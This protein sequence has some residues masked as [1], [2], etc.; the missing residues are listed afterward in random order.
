MKKYLTYKDEKSDKFWSIE[1]SDNSFTVVYGK[2]GTTGTSQVKTFKNNEKCLKEANK[3]IKEK[4]AKGY[5]EAEIPATIDNVTPAKKK[6]ASD[7]EKI[8]KE[9]DIT[10]PKRLKIFF[11]SG[12]YK[13]YEGMMVCGLP[14]YTADTKYKVKFFTSGMMNELLED[15]E[16]EMPDD[17]GA[18]Y[19]P[20]IE[21]DEESQFLGIDISKGD[22]CPVAMWEHE[23]GM[24]HLHSASLDEFLTKL[25]KKGENP[26]LVKLKK[27]FEKAQELYKKKKYQEALNLLNS[28]MD[29]MSLEIPKKYEEKRQMG[30]LFNL[31]GICKNNTNDGEGAVKDYKVA[32]ACGDSYAGLNIIDFYI[33]D[34]KDYHKAFE[35][36]VEF[37]KKYLDRYCLFHTFNYKGIIN[38]HLGNLVE[39]ENA[40]KKILEEYVISD[41]DKIE[42]TIENLKSIEKKKLPGYE[43]AVAILKWFGPKKY[44]LTAEQIKENRL[45]WNS[46]PSYGSFW[47]PKL[48]ESIKLKVEEP[49]DNDIATMFEIKNISFKKEE[50]INDLKPFEKLINL[51]EIDLYGDLENL[52]TLKNLK[53]L[54][55]ITYNGK[56]NKN[57]KVPSKL[58]KP[59]IR[60]A[61]DGNLDE[62]KEFLKKGVDINVKVDYETALYKA[63]YGN[64]DEIALFLVQQGANIYARVTD[65]RYPISQEC[66]PELWEKLVKEFKKRGGVKKENHFCIIEEKIERNI[67]QLSYL[68]NVEST[69]RLTNG[70]SVKD[71]FSVDA[72]F[73]M[74]T[75]YPGF[76]KDTTLTDCFITGHILIGNTKVKNYFES[77]KILNIEI[78]PVKIKNHAGEFIK[79]EYFIINPLA[80]DC[81]DVEKSEP[82]Y[83][84]ISPDDIDKVQSIVIDETLLNSDIQI[85]RIKNFS[86]EIF[87]RKTFANE[88]IKEGF[89]GIDFKFDV[90]E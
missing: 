77:K 30:E 6:I 40:Y 39:A 25:I 28:I 87:V 64:H 68:V 36:I 78:L 82:E 21:L 75:D 33:D 58:S 12:E 11:D 69:Y 62:V 48:K 15:N 2:T 29:G 86:Y 9:L 59:F 22:T 71:G 44:E 81:L 90:D 76:K 50:L 79:E 66:N 7:T 74:R 61:Y 45:W 88:L 10:L 5:T 35:F 47:Q 27:T 60:A 24:F 65:E 57:F 19:I 38:I 23:D 4:I 53:S 32:I 56:V 84:H 85:F 20:F 55:T 31:R 41:P 17:S 34:K 49:S 70:V 13:K 54:K 72:F 67:A 26:P 14:G 89:T 51:E 43:I 18:Y 16:I 83:N 63:I 42:K 3:L 8:E 80:V 37:E 52:D 46:L 73:P 1:V